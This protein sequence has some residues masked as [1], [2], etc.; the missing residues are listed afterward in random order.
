MS[1]LDWMPVSESY[2]EEDGALM[3]GLVAKHGV[4]ARVG[5]GQVFMEIWP[6][7]SPHHPNDVVTLT[8]TVDGDVVEEIGRHASPDEAMTAAQV[9]A[10]KHGHKYTDADAD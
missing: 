7:D 3:P 9:Y 4:I 10:D 8:L 6:S 5:V 1:Q 2:G